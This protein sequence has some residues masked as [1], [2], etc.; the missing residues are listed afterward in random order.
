MADDVERLAEGDMKREK[1]QGVLADLEM[2][3]PSHS[4][5]DRAKLLL[6]NWKALTGRSSLARLGWGVKGFSREVGRRLYYYPDKP[7]RGE[8]SI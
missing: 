8:P 2:T 5:W 3:L 6:Q 4:R 7:P 1:F